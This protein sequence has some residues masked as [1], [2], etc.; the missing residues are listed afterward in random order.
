LCVAAVEFSGFARVRV[1][2]GQAVVACPHPEPVLAVVGYPGYELVGE[3]VAKFM[4]HIEY[5]WAVG[6]YCVSFVKGSYPEV[7]V[8]VYIGG[9]N[10][11]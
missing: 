7:L 11:V 2:T 9:G 3:Y 4:V 5:P 10:V 1:E 8:A 6:K